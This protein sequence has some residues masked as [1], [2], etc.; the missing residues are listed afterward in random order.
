MHDDSGKVTYC[1]YHN[2]TFL[3]TLELAGREFISNF[4]VY[5][6]EKKQK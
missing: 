4:F 3:E 1:L 5:F 6:Q 2:N